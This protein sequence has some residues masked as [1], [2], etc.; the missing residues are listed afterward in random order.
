M[1]SIW[2]NS[3]LYYSPVR[4]SRRW[5]EGWRLRGISGWSRRSQITWSPRQRM[6]QSKYASSSADLCLLCLYPCKEHGK[7]CWF[8]VLSFLPLDYTLC[9]LIRTAGILRKGLGDLKMI[10]ANSLIQDYERIQC[11]LLLFLINR[12][13]LELVL[14]IY[15]HVVIAPSKIILK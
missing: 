4:S 15:I 7:A 8:G 9:M 14:V 1:I 6:C 2:F 12:W 5:R 13:S 11:V 10:N 3:D